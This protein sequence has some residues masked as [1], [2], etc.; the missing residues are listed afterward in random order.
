M[1]SFSFTSPLHAFAPPFIS[2]DRCIEVNIAG[3]HCAKNRNTPRSMC[4]DVILLCTFVRALTTHA[5]TQTQTHT[6]SANVQRWTGFCKFSL[7]C[8]FLSRQF[9]NCLGISI[10][11]KTSIFGI[12]CEAVYVDF[13]LSSSTSIDFIRNWWFGMEYGNGFL[14][15]L[16]KMDTKWD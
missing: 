4:C 1:F 6:G 13:S 14:D 9:L 3:D 10:Q 8:I 7:L 12:V 5:Q 11:P 15:L 2:F 16:T